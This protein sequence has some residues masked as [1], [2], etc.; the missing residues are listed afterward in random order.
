MG[1]EYCASYRSDSEHCLEC[2]YGDGKANIQVCPRISEEYSLKNK[3][4]PR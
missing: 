2:K 3:D 1:N 4:T